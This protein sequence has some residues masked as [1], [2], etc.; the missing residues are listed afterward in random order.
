MCDNVKINGPIS[1]VINALGTF[2]LFK[3]LKF[4]NSALSFTLFIYRGS[5][6]NAGETSPVVNLIRKT[7]S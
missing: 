3:V 7:N 2:L 6:P 5:N 1:K 4:K